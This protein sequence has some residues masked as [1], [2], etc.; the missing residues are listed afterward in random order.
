[1]NRC[2]VKITLLL[3]IVGLL[4]PG[5][6][7]AQDDVGRELQRFDRFLEQARNVVTT[8]DNVRGIQL[9]N[10]AETLRNSAVTDIQNRNFRDARNKLK[11]AMAKLETALKI[12]LD[13]PIRRLRS[14]VDA[15]LQRAEQEVLGRNHK[16]AERLIQEA[17]TNRDAAAEALKARRIQKGVEHFRVAKTLAQRAL[18][19][20]D[21]TSDR[22]EEERRKFETLKE[23]AQ[24]EVEKS[25]DE[26]A[27]QIFEQA[28]R[29]ARQA[30]DALREGNVSLA[31]KFYNQSVLLL[32]RAMD[33]AAG[34]SIHSVDRVEVALF[35]LRGSL[36][37]ARAALSDGEASRAQLL[38]ERA[39]RFAAEAEVS[40]S[41]GQN[42]EALWKIELAEKMVRRAV[43]LA[44]PGATLAVSDKIAYEIENTRSDIEAVRATQGANVPPDVEAMLRMAE[45]T[46]DRGER[47]ADAGFTRVA[48]EAVLASQRLLTRA[49]EMTRAPKPGLTREAIALRLSQLEE[50]IADAE[51][52][53]DPKETWTRRLIE[54]ARDLRQLAAESFREGHYHAASEGIQVA[55]ELLRK[56]Q[57][58]IRD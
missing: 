22:I 14:Q 31:K 15:L 29:L 43:R 2:F 41:K 51:G 53:T 4:M 19:M 34:D 20:V 37:R 57:K 3:F 32:L 17:R 42:S 40:L 58:A 26:R 18:D 28:L 25:G 23:R 52:K 45:S 8:F 44:Q 54:S 9:V 38:Y 30:D 12:T 33:L 1:M 46:L 49:E 55:F 11:L 5:N 16:E 6:L 35:R 13:G 10:E 36:E 48:L 47:A 39:R 27:R 21:A 50:A 7:A 56:S 24:E